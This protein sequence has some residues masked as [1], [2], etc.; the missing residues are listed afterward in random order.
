MTSPPDELERHS[1]KGEDFERHAEQFVHFFSRRVPRRLRATLTAMPNGSHLVDVGCGDGQLVWALMET[2][3]LP[4][5]STVLG[6]DISPVRVER[7][8]RLTNWPALLADGEKLTGIPDAVADLCISTM[9]VE[10]VPDD[11]AYAAALARIIKPG[12]TLYLTTVLRKKGAWY[13][14]KAPD[15]RRVLDPTHVREY[16]SIRDVQSTLEA[17]GFRTLEVGLERLV[18]PVLVPAVRMW[19]GLRPIH[20]AQRFF[21]RQPWSTLERIGLPIPRYREIQLVLR[22]QQKSD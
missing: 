14:R 1:L 17:A 3:L 11:A 6:V 21:L 20:D 13:F 4:D 8:Q 22:R 7:F 16:G 2:K 10:H 9:V 12:G 15:G 5:G 18:F 19:N